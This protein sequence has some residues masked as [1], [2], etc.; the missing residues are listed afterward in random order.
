MSEVL[1]KLQA[2]APDLTEEQALSWAEEL[3]QCDSI[4]PAETLIA[5]R[6]IIRVLRIRQAKDS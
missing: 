5:L 3:V 1:K 2:Q 4:S 6:T